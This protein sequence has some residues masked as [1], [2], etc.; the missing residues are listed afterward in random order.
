MLGT[1]G[2]A[3][4]G[5][6][7][8]AWRVT[9]WIAVSSIPAAVWAAWLFLAPSSSPL[10]TLVGPA[11]L[12]G[13]FVLAVATIIWLL[14]R[15]VL[16]PLRTIAQAVSQVAR[17]Q[18]VDL[19][20]LPAR[21]DELGILARAVERMA[22]E[23]AEHLMRLQ[24][25]NAVCRSVQQAQVLEMTASRLGEFLTQVLE[26]AVRLTQARYGAV[27]V[28][29]ERGER[30]T[31]FFTVGLDDATRAAIGSPPTGRGLLGFLAH[32]DQPVRLKDLTAHP[33]AVGFPPHHPPMR[34]FLGQSIKAHGRLYG[35]I[36]LTEKVGADEFSET[37]A[38][39]LSILAAQAGVAI[40][41]GEYL[42]QLQQ[43]KERYRHL[44]ESPEE[45]IYGVDLEG[46][47]T[48]INRAG[49]T[50]LGYRSDEVLG[51]SM[52]ALVHHTRRD[53]SPY[54]AEECPSVRAIQIGQG[55]RLDDEVLWRKDGTWFPVEFCASPVR[56]GD[57]V[58][59]AV[60]AFTDIS[61]R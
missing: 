25:V 1:E 58:T 42:K 26:Q 21:D 31:Q 41:D 27:G 19:G 52:H 45:G 59:G 37:D 17:R 43:A 36:Y 9:G 2:S 57:R 12:L 7:P 51:Q 4:V 6:S 14:K 30:L 16:V 10:G 34:S 15:Q 40:E 18:P 13:C 61:V 24:G 49:A 33:R 29:D 8:L 32:E 35:R 60:V 48:F 54:Q 22:H 53:G 50:M 5:R 39:V 28:F 47:C 44:L 20:T 55:Y 23:V 11:G 38:M 56:E 46:R 3:P